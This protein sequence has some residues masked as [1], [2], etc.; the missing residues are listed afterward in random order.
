M[1]N[2]SLKI[3]LVDSSLT[4]T[5]QFPGSM[6]IHEVCKELRDRFGDGIGGADH[7]LLLTSKGKWLTPAKILDFYDLV[8]GDELEFRKKHIKLKVQT[9]DNSVKT[10]YVDESLPVSQLVESICERIGLNNPE[11]YS[12][13]PKTISGREGQAGSS[14]TIKKKKKEEKK[15]DGDSNS[16]LHPDRALREQGI[17]EED[18]VIL[19]KKFFF[20]DLNIDRNDPVQLGLL[21]EQAKES[22]VGGTNPCKKEEAYQFAAMQLQAQFG[23]FDKERHKSGFIDLKDFIPPEYRKSKDMEKHIYQ[24]YSKL[25]NL[26]ELNAKFRYVQLTRSLKTYG[27]TFFPVE[28]EVT[29]GKKR[30]YEKVLLGIT[31][32]S[33]VKLDCETKDTIQEWRLTQLRRWATTP[34]GFV[35]DFGDYADA[36]LS[37]KTKDGE[38]IS[39]LISG[40]IDIIIRKRKEAEKVVEQEPEER[41]TLEEYTKSG[42]AMTVGMVGGHGAIGVESRVVPK[43][44][45]MSVVPISGRTTVPQFADVSPIQQSLLQKLYNGFAAVS[46]GAQDMQVPANLPPLGND[47]AALQW[48]QHTIDVNGE[49]VA[50]Q[51]AAILGAAGGL[52]SNLSGYTEE[53][54]YELVGTAVSTISANITQLV[55]GV[56]LLAGLHEDLNEQQNLL[57]AGRGIADAVSALLESA[58][59][60]TMGSLEKD[61]FFSKGRPLAESCSKLLEL[62]GS[63]EVDDHNQALLLDA[64]KQVTKQLNEF[65]GVA[66]NIVSSL[67]EENDQALH[68]SNTN[69]LQSYMATVGAVATTVAPTVVVSSCL[70]QLLEA[71]MIVCDSIDATVESAQPSINNRLLGQLK[72]NAQRVEETIAKLID[73]AKRTGQASEH[74][75]L[76]T[77]YDAVLNS[78]GTMLDTMNNVDSVVANTKDLTMLSMQFVNTI[79]GYADA[80]ADSDEHD[81]LINAAKA[82]GEATSHL[83][84]CAKDTALNPSQKNQQALHGAI[85]ELK[86]AANQAAGPSLRVNAFKKLAKIVKDVIG[87]SNQ[88]ISASRTVAQ[89]N[90]DQES[91]LQLNQAAKRVGDATPSITTVMKASVN[92]PEDMNI[93]IKLID[94]AKKYIF[95]NSQLISSARV[96]GATTTD[97]SAQS[98]LNNTTKQLED[99][100]TALQNV[101]NL[102]EEISAGIELDAAFST[103][104]EHANQ[105]STAAKDLSHLAVVEGYDSDSLGDV[106]LAIK[107]LEE[108]LTLLLNGVQQRNTRIA[109]S[110]ATETVDALKSLSFTLMSIGAESTDEN[111]R[112]QLLDALSS[113]TNTMGFFVGR[114]KEVMQNK[115]SD[116]DIG[117]LHQKTIDVL[118]NCKHLVPGQRDLEEAYRNINVVEGTLDSRLNV[119]ADNVSFQTAQ[120]RLQAAATAVTVGTNAVVASVRLTPKDVQKACTNYE[121]SINKL[122]EASG[123]Y[124]SVATHDLNLKGKVHDNLG[125]VC[126]K[127]S[128][129]FNKAIPSFSDPTNTN[130][131]QELTFAAR[132]VS[133]SIN[134]LLDVSAA[135]APGHTD[136]NNALQ[137][138]SN[139]TQRLATFNT[140]N[141]NENSYMETVTALSAVSKQTNQILATYSQLSSVDP[142]KLATK[143]TE[144]AKA[145]VQAIDNTSYAAYL[146]GCADESSIAATAPLLDQKMFTELADTIRENCRLLVLPGNDQAAILKHAAI[147]AEKTSAICN[148]ARNAAKDPEIPPLAKQQFSAMAKDIAGITSDVVQAIKRL[149][150]N[151]GYDDARADVEDACDPLIDAVDHL[152]AYANSSDFSGTD[153]KISESA[154][155]SQ[156]PIIEA[157]ENLINSS[158][159]VIT[160]VKLLCVNPNDA[161]TCNLLQA[162]AR[163]ATDASQSA[164]ILVAQSAPGQKECGDAINQITEFINQIDAAIVDSTVNDLI[165]IEATHSKLQLADFVR[166]L[167]SLADV[168]AKGAKTDSRILASSIV[169][170]PVNFERIAVGGIAIAS[171][172]I[173]TQA[174]LDMLELLKKV[175]DSL[176]RYVGT[177][178]TLGGSSRNEAGVKKLEEERTALRS[179][180]PKLVSLL[181]GSRDDSGEFTKAA[182]SIEQTI[183]SLEKKTPKHAVMPYH[184]CA[185]HIGKSGKEFNEVVSEI[186]SKAKKPSEF[187]ALAGKVAENYE[188]ITNHSCNAIAGTTDFGIQQS[189]QSIQRNLGGLSINLIEAIRQLSGRSAADQ[190]ARAK[191]NAAGREVAVNIANMIATA[192]E[193]SK[194]IQMC[195]KASDNISSLQGELDGLL[196]FAQAGQL[197][198]YDVKDSFAKHKEPLLE[199]AREMTEILR[200]FVSGVTG[201]Q[202]ELGKLSTAAATNTQILLKIAREAAVSITS[203]DKNM[204]TE[205][206]SAT[207][208]VVDNLGELVETSTAACGLSPDDPVMSQVAAKLKGSFMAIGELV[209]ITKT[210][211]DDSTQGIRAISG[212]I[213]DIN[214]IGKSFSSSEPAQGTALP[215]EV[216]A[217]A[218]QLAT[219]AA[220][221]V[222]AS[223]GNQDELVST[224]NALRKQFADLIRAAKAATEK[225]PEEHKADMLKSIFAS[226]E[227]V[228]NLLSSIKES[229][230]TTN[231]DSKQKMQVAAKDITVSVNHVVQ[232]ANKLIPSGYVDVN[233]PNV[234]AERELLSAAAFIEAA[235]KKLAALAP[236]PTSRAVDENLTF[237]EQIV[238]AAKAIASATGALVRSATTAQRE[239]VALG[240]VQKS[241]NM[242]FDDGQ[243]SDGLVSAAKLVAAATGELCDAGN[244]AIKGVVE[245]EKVIVC[246]K[247]VGAATQQLLTAAVVKSDANSTGIIRLQAAGRA[248]TQA[249]DNLVKAAESNIALEKADEMS[250]MMNENSVGGLMRG[251]VAEME[252]QIS[253]LKMEKELEKARAKLAGVRKG[254]YDAGKNPGAR[255]GA[256]A[257]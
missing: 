77:Q 199:A 245:R 196:I 97:P 90:R 174:Q 74:D 161:D 66:K 235:S 256:Q 83:V 75:Q 180:I 190:A 227:A 34:N 47:S 148:A 108:N 191:L 236:P 253:I 51:I 69:R 195:Q 189:L 44:Q 246:S 109:G 50:A 40:Y 146:I 179:S 231:P 254:K 14:A 16:W 237:E 226:T 251:R 185:D 28:E 209:E 172:T 114:S 86:L 223:N 31:K 166:N 99:N 241:D 25:Q 222:A 78:I 200:T 128:L 135:A 152:E 29:K 228:R 165:P 171:N 117:A 155:N 138:I 257:Q 61:D 110:A 56:K 11:E 30:S 144:L 224:A 55:Q 127:I 147:I 208:N 42:K 132:G 45:A 201:T 36:Y 187:R 23:N 123:I 178:K 39:Q 205:L 113:L 2:I 211:S 33:V 212:A 153:A 68:I 103:L 240:K 82:L 215:E 65:N 124:S 122:I 43:S 233:D 70:D 194:G 181:E 157:S 137:I 177:A 96:A 125:E 169:E 239:L 216:A 145:I 141:G 102:A 79:K 71:C 58:Q 204:Q 38:K 18:I 49:A 107:N 214:E 112:R 133:D 105:V 134:H 218:K 57:K 242:Y 54:D 41:A 238:E 89:S 139:A 202:D 91:Q 156:K 60:I 73:R 149:A 64:A 188:L 13:I 176:L 248:V 168:I 154:Y 252:A 62:I 6:S 37:V 143:T 67:R 85:V 22:I 5:L 184:V 59:P 129:L 21:Y 243:W 232:A 4:K 84:S 192:K 93:Q 183:S 255:A 116:A 136:C 167:A 210:L 158:M 142:V 118:D 12:I 8:S 10:V 220:A 101:C 72:E 48:K 9:L 130:F 111:Y 87:S 230:T 234:V 35:L 250:N 221:L 175:G 88:L 160:A 247:N 104:V 170:I 26:S 173:E 162:N 198:P 24:E 76:T 7:G 186:I 63:L 94:A 98:L 121:A 100:L 52:Y 203:A 92:N 115:G 46:N 182:E 19:K 207:K 1:S 163:S 32:S 53:M 106:V 126:K 164:I 140:A 219:A 150:V 27:V 3:T 197:D 17:T 81:G 120:I 131:R 244:S 119:K 249:T 213:A 20:T 225:A 15:E 80:N 159:E 217:S 95:P 206:L 229:K 193:G 151:P